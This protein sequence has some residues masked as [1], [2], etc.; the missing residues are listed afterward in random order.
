MEKKSFD[1]YVS[2]DI[3]KNGGGKGTRN[4][5]PDST[6][7]EEAPFIPSTRV[8]HLGRSPLSSHSA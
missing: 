5:S 4:G 7:D 3:A 6:V 2:D 1:L 8:S